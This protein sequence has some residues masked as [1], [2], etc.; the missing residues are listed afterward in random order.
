MAV[1][2]QDKDGIN[3]SHDSSKIFITMITSDLNS[4]FIYYE[5]GNF[6]AN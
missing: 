4:E 2:F 1:F 5:K 6:L 3:N